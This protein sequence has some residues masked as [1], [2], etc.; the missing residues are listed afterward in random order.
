[1][2]KCCSMCPTLWHFTKLHKNHPY[3]VEGAKVTQHVSAATLLPSAQLP[4][5]SPPWEGCS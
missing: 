5:P 3:L 4:V 1:M 2:V